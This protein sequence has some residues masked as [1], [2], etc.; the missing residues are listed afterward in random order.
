MIFLIAVAKA[1]DDADLRI[2]REITTHEVKVYSYI[3]DLEYT[4]REREI[5]RRGRRPNTI[6]VARK[7][8]E[9]ILKELGNHGW[10]RDVQNDKEINF[11]IQGEAKW[12]GIMLTYNL[13]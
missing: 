2:Y 11:G 6:T 7:A 3:N 1:L 13:S 10:T 8:R 5:R 4:A 12:I 9:L